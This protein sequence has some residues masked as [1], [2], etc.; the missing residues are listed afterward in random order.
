MSS[1]SVEH[2]EPAAAAEAA[3]SVEGMDCAS[4]IA[5]VERAVAR[6]GGVE[7]CQVNLARGRA[8][9]RF[10]PTRTDLEHIAGAITDAGYPARP[11]LP[12]GNAGSAEEARLHR[13]QHEAR[14][15]FW[16]AMTAII[17]WLPLE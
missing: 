7:S 8:Q 1:D 11:E 13:Q 4:C 12:D 9:V 2:D 5:H 15:W 3:F 16:R 14:A 10:D 6:L 17:L